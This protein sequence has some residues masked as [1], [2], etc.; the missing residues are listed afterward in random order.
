MT[1]LTLN[2]VQKIVYSATSSAKALFALHQAGASVY[3]SAF[4]SEWY[5]VQVDGHCIAFSDNPKDALFYVFFDKY[6]V[7]KEV[8]K[9]FLES[10]QQNTSSVPAIEQAQPSMGTAACAAEARPDLPVLQ[11]SCECSKCKSAHG[12]LN[13]Y[14]HGLVTVG[15]PDCWH[16]DQS[17]ISVMA[18]AFF[19]QL[20]TESVDNSTPEVT[21]FCPS[22]DYHSATAQKSPEA[23]FYHVSCSQCG[24]DGDREQI[25][26]SP[27]SL[28]PHQAQ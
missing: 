1:T 22:C 28:Q 11:E 7:T 20:S 19:S 6:M 25:F 4:A 16:S 17:L 3:N 9:Q 18:E 2:Q 21:V 23:D 24:L 27:S 12:I 15:C 10:L 14:A 5:S 13:V 8:R 26:L